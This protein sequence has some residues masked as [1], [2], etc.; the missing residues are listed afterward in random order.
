[1]FINKKKHILKL[2]TVWVCA[3]LVCKSFHADISTDELLV[4]K[5]GTGGNMF[6]IKDLD[7]VKELILMRLELAQEGL[8]Y[9]FQKGEFRYL[10]DDTIIARVGKKVVIL[11]SCGIRQ[12][13]DFAALRAAKVITASV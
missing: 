1:M 12:D 3:F 10:D 2:Y 7:S 8:G 9:E 4:E 13:N 5:I 11:A 6:E